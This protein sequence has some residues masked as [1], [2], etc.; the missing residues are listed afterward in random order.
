[1]KVGEYA[2]TYDG[3]I[4][5]IIDDNFAQEETR[6]ELDY[7]NKL[8]YFHQIIKS[9]PN[10][11]DLVQIGDYVDGLKVINIVEHLHGHKD[12]VMTNG[13]FQWATSNDDY[14]IKSIVTREQFE[15]VAYHV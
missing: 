8:Y 10:I 14:D 4:G 1:M 2:R 12:I 15:E 13:K 3:V 9:S 7:N 5:K 6:Y 11:I